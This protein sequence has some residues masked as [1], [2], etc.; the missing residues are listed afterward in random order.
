MT[1]TAWG[2]RLLARDTV[3]RATRPQALMVIGLLAG[4]CVVSILLF[5]TMRDLGSTKGDLGQTRRDLGTSKGDTKRLENQVRKLGATPVTR[6]TA[7]PGPRSTTVIV[8]PGGGRGGQGGSG[9]TGGNGSSA[10]Q[11]TSKPTSNP[12]PTTRP[13]PSPSPSPT[14]PSGPVCRNLGICL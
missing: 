2:T 4:L 7:A 13:S 3:R 14:Q 11:P 5:F 8:V 6:P 12:Q 1:K 10:R 9:G